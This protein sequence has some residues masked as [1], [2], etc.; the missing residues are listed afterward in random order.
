MSKNFFI[1]V[2]T[3]ILL[4]LLL[5]SQIRIKGEIVDFN[6]IPSELVEVLLYNSD[7]TAVKNEFSDINGGFEIE[8]NTGNY[9]LQLRQLGEVLFEKNIELRKDLN[10][11]IIKIKIT[12]QLQTVVIETKKKLIERKVDR[13]V[14]NVENS[15]LATG[16][17]AIDALKVTPGIKVQ[18]D[19]IKMIGK[20]GMALMVDDR[21]I[22]LSEDDLI[23]YL[24]TI[25]SDNIKSIEVITTPPAKYNAEGNSGLINIK[26]K[27]VK[28]DS[29][30]T[31]TR[32]NYNQATYATA[33]FGANLSY[34]K[35]KL[36]LILDLS[37]RNV[38]SIY[39][40]DV[41]Y[42]YPTENWKN[43]VFNKT[44]RN[45]F[46]S[47][48]GLTYDL[49]SK[50]KFGVQY[51]GSF[52][53]SKVNEDNL[54]NIYNY[55]TN[56][57][58]GNLNSSG[59]TDRNINNHSLNLSLATKLDSIG[60]KFTI[61]ADY[62]IYDS[63][64]A[65]N[66]RNENNNY[67]DLI[68]ER[69][70]NENGNNQK[71]SNFSTDIDFE[72]PYKWASINFG[73]KLNATN[74]N[75]DLETLIYENNNGVY[76]LNSTQ[77]NVFKYKENNQA[78]YFS[79]TKKLGEKWELKLGIRT[80][81]V[82]TTGF[83]K[84]TNSPNKYN[85]FK[86][87]PTLYFSYKGNEDNTLSA[88]YS[89]R[90]NRPSYSDMNPAKWYFNSNSYEEGNPFLQPSFS[91]NLEF[92]HKFKQLLVSTLSFSKTKN[93]FGQ[94]TVHDEINGIQ[95]FIRRNYFD[96]SFIGL[97]ET[98]TFDFFTWWNSMNNAGAFYSETNVYSEYLE[99]KYSGWGS[100]V[101]TTNSFVLNKN[102]TFSGQ[103]A[104]TYS[105]PTSYGE[106]NISSYSNLNIAI[107]YALLNKKL[108]L[109]FVIDDLLKT[110]QYTIY[111][112]SQD[113]DQSFRQYYDTQS[114]RISVSYKFGSDKINV[115][116]RSFGNQEEKNR[117]GN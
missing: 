15:I 66:F 68:T 101:S 6:N 69:Q 108:Q 36:G 114:F 2:L 21:M 31:T 44:D 77:V 19:A 98:L 59:F 14:F 65:N 25:S 112:K 12:N 10:L 70:Y 34:Q 88:N 100:Y 115:K 28:K 16:G 4:P 102:K 11:G 113:I 3:L 87:F 46:S 91:D 20:R 58:D 75:S 1:T 47:L 8:A 23:N 38:E 27:K 40:N 117:I 9:R 99:P 86:I 106:S 54:S 18:N 109:S 67:I 41:T 78:L 7:S 37:E 42:K 51:L 95:K 105:F 110:N 33:T 89:R 45:V 90:I 92:S 64:K 60:K 32:A 82:Q 79:S 17:D 71:I 39:T 43:E 73:A 80:E 83:S 72:M 111:N 24:K 48:I 107:R 26:L 76:V 35:N 22:Q 50:S 29:W 30:S 52:N 74:S 81:F 56:S 97:D 63:N 62:F 103:L 53:K 104:Y 94:L 93:G 5:F 49:T 96:G 116:Q 61:N 84:T 57:L 85:Y 13:L 55:Q